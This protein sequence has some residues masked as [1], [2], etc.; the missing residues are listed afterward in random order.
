MGAY[1]SATHHQYGGGAGSGARGEGGPGGILSQSGVSHSALVNS[2][3]AAIHLGHSSFKIGNSNA[4]AAA[5]AGASNSITNNNGPV[6]LGSTYG[7]LGNSSGLHRE[8]NS[9]SHH[10]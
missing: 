2:G 3:N 7:A 4:V 10:N 5:A 6:T 1:N 8:A 9:S